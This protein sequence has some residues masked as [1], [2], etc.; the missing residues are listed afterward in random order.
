M[1]DKPWL[2]FYDKGVPE[3][4]KPYPDVPLFKFL[5]DNAAKYPDHPA[6]H[7][8]PSH[9]GFAKSKL[10]YA[11]LNNLS[12]RMAA[13]LAALGVKKGDRVAIFM[14]NIPQFIITFY[15]I[16]KAGAVVVASNPTY[17]EPELEHQL[18]DSGA[19]ALVCMSRFYGTVQKVLP[20]TQIK[21][22]IVTNIKDYM[23]PL[24]RILFGLAKEKKSG[25]KVTLQPGH[26]KFTDVLQKYLP[27]QRPKVEVTAE[28]KALFQYSGGTTGVPKAAVALHR[29]LVANTLQIRA[30]LSDCREGDEVM[31]TAI[32]L[33]HV[34]G[35]VVG[36]S[37]AVQM[38]ASIVVVPNPR[39]L[40]SVLDAIDTYRPTIFPGVPRMY[41]ALNNHPEIAKHDLRSI[42]V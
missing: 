28:D 19:V 25:D 20:K 26:L 12:D 41:N 31:L 22:V 29:N 39:D 7:F 37:A 13:A 2:K 17:T 38:A 23:S 5:E 3:S 4:L 9:Q 11:E 30:W 1:T 21:T 24:L 8:K 18:K 14:P 27:S 33:F 36:M 32:P 35:M 34:Y 16:L 40:E 6:I 10:T 42:R 15:G